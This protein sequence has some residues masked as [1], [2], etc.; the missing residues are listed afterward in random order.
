MV[1]R[2]AGGGVGVSVSG[3]QAPPRAQAKQAPG[4]LSAAAES[5]WQ[6]QQFCFCPAGEARVSAAEWLTSRQPALRLLQHLSQIAL[7]VCAAAV[8][9]AQDAGTPQPT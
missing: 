9:V 8:A 3:W 2:K 7:W 4:M 5:I 6:A 1:A